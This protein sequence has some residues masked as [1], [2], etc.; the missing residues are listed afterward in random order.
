MTTHCN[1]VLAFSD[2]SVKVGVTSR[3][4]LRF[5]EISRSKKGAASLVR[6]IHAP[7]CTKDQAFSIEA[8]LCS[9]LNYRAAPGTR[10]WFSGGSEEFSFMKQTTGMFWQSIC[11]RG[12]RSELEYSEV[13]A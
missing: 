11:N 5:S 6:A 7:F 12:H 9:L 1:Y 8:K 10:E 13:A 3:P 2:G 4:Q